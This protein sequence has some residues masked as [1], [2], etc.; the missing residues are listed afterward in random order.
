MKIK[1]QLIGNLLIFEVNENPI[2]QP[3][4]TQMNSSTLYSRW[5]IKTTEKSL[6]LKE[7]ISGFSK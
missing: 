3:I 4:N 6:E 1:Y 7:N 2:L 5:L